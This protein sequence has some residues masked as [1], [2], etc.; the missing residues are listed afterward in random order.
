MTSNLQNTLWLWTEGAFSRR[1]MYTL[2]IKGLVLSTS[3]LLQGKTT[4]SN[5]H[6]NTV[7]VDPA[8]GWVCADP[9]DPQPDGATN[10]CMRTTDD[11]TGEVFFIYESTS[12]ILYLEEL[13]PENPMR[14]CS[15]VEQA[16]MMDIIGR[17]NL[18]AIDSNY[19][20]RNTVPE[21][22]AVMGVA[23]E[24]QQQSTA[25]NAKDQEIKGLLKIQAWAE[26]NG[27]GKRGWITPGIDGPGLADVTL[28]SNVRFIDLIY[29]IYM[30]D[31][32]RL[33]PLS[34]WYERFKKLPW[35]NDFEERDGIVPAILEFG[36]SS[37][38]AWT[39][40]KG[41]YGS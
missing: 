12:I 34:E 37:R 8:K 16:M 13:Y 1:V 23:A 18:V 38:A 6:I 15:T 28:A 27:L 11:A 3:D 35:W 2:L 10:P 40:E 5:L 21:H 9:D 7:K 41:L 32:A 26:L 31:D 33:K 4:E 25:L 30:F 24:D 19:F 20:L 39:K 14:P 29:G 17:I 22:G 36:K